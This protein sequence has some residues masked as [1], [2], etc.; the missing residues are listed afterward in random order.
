MPHAMREPYPEDFYKPV[1]RKIITVDPGTSRVIGLGAYP[2][3]ELEPDFDFAYS[4]D[5]EDE[6]GIS[7]ER[8]DLPDQSQYLVLYMFHNYGDV[9]CTV[10]IRRL[11]NQRK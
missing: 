1:T 2:V 5:M 9:P 10:A 8:L 11:S 6:I 4:P 7:L 3:D